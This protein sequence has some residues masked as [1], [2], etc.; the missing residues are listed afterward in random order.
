VE[1]VLPGKFKNKLSFFNILSKQKMKTGKKIIALVLVIAFVGSF[2]TSCRSSKTGCPVWS[3][4][5]SK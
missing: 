4:E 5:I 3:I 2:L 1:V